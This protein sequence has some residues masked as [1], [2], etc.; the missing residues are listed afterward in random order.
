MCIMKTP[1]KYPIKH[2]LNKSLAS[3]PFAR[4][5]LKDDL[6]VS[7]LEENRSLLLL[8][9]ELTTNKCSSLNIP[10]RP[11]AQRLILAHDALICVADE[12]EIF[13]CGILVAPH[14]VVHDT[15]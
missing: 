5:V 14:L 2:D 3:L 12:Q 4:S 6:T 1:A 15:L 13:L 7:L 11:L 10:L 9:M 8:R